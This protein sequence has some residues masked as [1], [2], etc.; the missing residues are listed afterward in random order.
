MPAGLNRLP[1]LMYIDKKKD[2]FFSGIA[3]FSRFAPC[4]GTPPLVKPP[5]QNDQTRA[6]KNFGTAKTAEIILPVTQWNR[7][8]R[9]ILAFFR[10][11][12]NCVALALL[13]KLDRIF[14]FMNCVVQS[15]IEPRF[16]YRFDYR[17]CLGIV[18]SF[19]VEEQ[20]NGS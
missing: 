18:V 8:L 17:Y 15:L 20:A 6:V 4:S 12:K 13:C 14:S 16:F 1:N 3:E 5:C 19:F 11:K 9:M 7:A 10:Q 2:S